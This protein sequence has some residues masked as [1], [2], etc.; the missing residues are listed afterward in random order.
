MQMGNPAARRACIRVVLLLFVISTSIPSASGAKAREL[1]RVSNN[2]GATFFVSLNGD[3]GGPGTVN[4]PWATIN[5]AAKQATAGDTVVVRGGRYILS[6]QIR[7]QNSGRPHAW[8]TF[9]GYP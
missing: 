9:V 7:V 8:I 5:H 6:A 3:D 1:V 4:R 2:G